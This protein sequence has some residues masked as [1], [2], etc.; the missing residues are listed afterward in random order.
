MASPR[1]TDTAP[2]SCLALQDVRGKG[3]K[4]GRPVRGGRRRPQD[5]LREPDCQPLVDPFVQGRAALRNEVSG[6]EVWT[7]ASQLLDHRPRQGATAVCEV[8][9]EV[10][11]VDGASGRRRRGLD[12]PAFLRGLGGRD[13]AGDPPVP[14]AY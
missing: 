14:Q 10:L 11:R 12:A 2:P 3:L 1:W 8:D 7:T 6:V 4:F 9:A 13:E 5:E